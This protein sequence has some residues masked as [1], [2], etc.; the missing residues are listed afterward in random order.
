MSRLGLFPLPLVLVPTERVPL[1]VFEPRYKELIGECIERGGEFGVLLEKP[2]GEAHDVGTRAAIA[3]VLRVLPDGRMYGE[4]ALVGGELDDALEPEL[5]LD[6]L[7]RLP[8]LVGRELVDRRADE[9]PARIRD[10]S[11]HGRTLM[12]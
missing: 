11:A 3:E 9:R 7:D 5:A 10:A 1:R 2:D 4:R 8:R 12:V 6:V